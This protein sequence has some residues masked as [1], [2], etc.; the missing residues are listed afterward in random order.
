MAVKLTRV[1]IEIQVHSDDDGDVRLTAQCALI[2][3][4][5][6]FSHAGMEPVH[7]DTRVVEETYDNTGLT[8]KR[9]AP[10]RV[11]VTGYAGLD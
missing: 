8:C 2:A 1:I 5:Q 4:S 10:S 7:T 9:A 3:A 6:R 11:I